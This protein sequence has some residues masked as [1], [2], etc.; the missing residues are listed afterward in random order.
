MTEPGRQA[1]A[2]STM[3]YIPIP[4]LE[5]AAALVLCTKDSRLDFCLASLTLDIRLVSSRTGL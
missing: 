2:R 3:I 5:T 1:Q 4:L